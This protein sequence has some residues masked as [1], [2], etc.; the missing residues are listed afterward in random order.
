MKPTDIYCKVIWKGDD[1][2]LRDRVFLF[3]IG[4]KCMTG[5][6]TGATRLPQSSEFEIEISFIDSKYFESEKKIG[7][8]ITIQ[9]ASKVLAEGIITRILSR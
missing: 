7:N 1:E 2:S 4:G 9:E 6:I 8:R 5:S 3:C